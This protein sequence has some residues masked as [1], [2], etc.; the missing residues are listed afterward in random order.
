MIRKSILT[1]ISLLLCGMLTLSA[2]AQTTSTPAQQPQTP[3][4]SAG[5]QRQDRSRWPQPPAPLAARPIS[6]PAP[7]ETTLPNGLQVVILESARLPLANYR[8]VFRTGT[9]SDPADTIGLTGAVASLLDDGTP[10]RT[11]EQIADEVAGL[12]ASLFVNAGADATTVSASALAQHTDRIMDLIADIA[13]RPTFPLNELDLYKRNTTQALTV[14]RTQPGFLA[15]ERISRVLFGQHPYSVISPTAESVAALTREKLAAHHRANFV[16]NNAFLVIVGNVQR[17]AIM[18]RINELF[19]RW[20]RGQVQEAR[21]PSPP[22]RTART[23]YVV[24]RPGSAQSNIIIGNIAINRTSPDYFPSL[25]MNMILGGSATARLFQNLREDKGYTYGAY[26]SLDTR[27]LAGSF[28]ASSQ[29]RTPVTGP[30]L[31]EFFNELERIR[32]ETVSESDLN[33]AKAYLTGVFPLQLE[34]QAGL[35]AQLVNIKLFGLP[36]DYLRTYRDRINA[37]TREDV[38]RV[39][40][41][42]VTPEQVAIVIVGDAPAIMEQI[43]PFSQNI[44]LYDAAGNRM[45]M[46]AA[47]GSNTQ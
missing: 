36:A 1:I 6:I 44:E 33:D 11:S 38:Q 2:V 26:S 19:G 45:E 34:T 4:P 8:L 31:R 35:A 21:F 40:R 47:P 28:R 43:R 30:A 24:N 3:A 46:P 15:E 7:Y 37:V 17:E 27:R 16:P 42:Y 10:T 32:N 41:R 25:V 13:L 22:A 18:R 20:E 9:T 29:V 12:G 14:Q 23:I 39:A 5:Q